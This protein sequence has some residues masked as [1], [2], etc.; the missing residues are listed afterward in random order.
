M[1][2]N[3]LQSVPVTIRL[4][5]VALNVQPNKP[6]TASRTIWLRLTG[7]KQTGNSV[8]INLRTVM[9]STWDHW[10][11]FHTCYMEVMN[12]FL[13]LFKSKP[14]EPP[15]LNEELCKL[16]RKKHNLFRKWKSLKNLVIT[17]STKQL[18]IS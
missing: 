4:S 2:K 7:L 12:Q 15:W 8:I 1:L 18:E 17:L 9:T 16:C 3:S 13:K 6:K 14:K 5:N 11:H 10:D